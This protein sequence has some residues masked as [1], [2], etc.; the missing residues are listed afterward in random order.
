MKGRF[1][2]DTVILEENQRSRRKLD[3]IRSKDVGDDA[4]HGLAIEAGFKVWIE[5]VRQQSGNSSAGKTRFDSKSS[6]IGAIALEE[7][8]LGNFASRWNAEAFFHRISHNANATDITKGSEH[9]V[10]RYIGQSGERRV[11]KA[12]I[13]GKIWTLRIQSLDLPQFPSP[14]AESCNGARYSDARN[15]PFPE[16][17]K[18][19][20]EHAVY[21]RTAPTASGDRRLSSK[22]GVDRI[23]RRESNLGF[24]Q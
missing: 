20:H 6:L 1:H 7:Q 17:S 3:Q 2:A 4:G 11:L 21:P 9:Y 18:H 5:F 19:S 15:R 10:I 12:T 23:S 13:P 22:I 8:L 14:G 16:W 24:H